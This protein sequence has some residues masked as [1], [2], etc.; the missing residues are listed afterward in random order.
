MSNLPE[1][2]HT[3]RSLGELDDESKIRQKDSA[4]TDYL[5]VAIEVEPEVMNSLLTEEVLAHWA[6]YMESQAAGRHLGATADPIN[7]HIDAWCA[8]WG[9]DQHRVWGAAFRL[10]GC[11]F[12]ARSSGTPSPSRFVSDSLGNVTPLPVES[13]HVKIAGRSIVPQVKVEL[14][15]LYWEPTTETMTDAL[16]RIMG[17]IEPIILDQLESIRSGYISRGYV[18]PLRKRDQGRHFEWFARNR[19]RGESVASIARSLE[20]S[21]EDNRDHRTVQRAIV[22]VADVLGLPRRRPGRPKRRQ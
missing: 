17:S 7:A 10:L 21:H 6:T 14:P 3:R 15:E 19:L 11:T 5:Q 20:S 13:Y 4:W 2:S 1:D 16:A 12:K 22:Q 18:S 8:R 9:F